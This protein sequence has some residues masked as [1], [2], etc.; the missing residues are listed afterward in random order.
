MSA[1]FAMSNRPP[2]AGKEGS[3]TFGGVLKA[4]GGERRVKL[5]HRIDSWVLSILG[6]R[7]SEVMGERGLSW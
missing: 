1:S 2:P 6:E 3:R 4:L 7:G 5:S